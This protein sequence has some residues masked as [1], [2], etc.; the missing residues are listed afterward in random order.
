MV[1]VDN[2]FAVSCCAHFSYN[3]AERQRF[4]QIETRDVVTTM[5]YKRNQKRGQK[6]HT[7]VWLSSEIFFNDG[8]SSQVADVE[9]LNLGPS[10]LVRSS[11]LVIELLR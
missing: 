4:S 10:Y 3:R 8:Y 11:L 6:L 1:K 2:S 9:R 7:S 5:M